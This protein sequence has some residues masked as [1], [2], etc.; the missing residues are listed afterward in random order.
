MAQRRIM[1]DSSKIRIMI[2]NT[3]MNLVFCARLVSI[4]DCG[5]KKI[6]YEI[7]ESPLI[8]SN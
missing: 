7:L 3:T 6:R 4:A 8:S 1:I 5:L 2:T